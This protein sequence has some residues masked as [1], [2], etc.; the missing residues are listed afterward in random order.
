MHLK[1]DS[2]ISM[3]ILLT[4]EGAKLPLESFKLKQYFLFSE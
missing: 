1:L 3:G 4:K 2:K